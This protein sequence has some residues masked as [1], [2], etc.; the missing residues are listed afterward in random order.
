MTR[1]IPGF[2]RFYLPPNT[3]HTWLYS[4]AA[5]HHRPLAGTHC[6][7]PRMDEICFKGTGQK[8]FWGAPV[9]S[10]PTPLLKSWRKRATRGALSVFRDG[11]SCCPSAMCSRLAPHGQRDA[12]SSLS[13]AGT[14]LFSATSTV[15]TYS[16]VDRHTATCCCSVY[17]FS[18]WLRLLM[19]WHFP[20]SP[21][22][23]LFTY[24]SVTTATRC[25]TDIFNVY[26]TII[27]IQRWRITY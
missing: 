23:C 20:P 11:S 4:S 18:V 6:A 27:F 1:V 24:L 21:S 19:F 10:L 12:S 14:C 9:R 15:V 5:E 3:S 25:Q 8:S 22:S 7:Y 16:V 17:C 26:S 2:T 13:L